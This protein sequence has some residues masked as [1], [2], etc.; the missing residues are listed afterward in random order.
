MRNLTMV[1][2]PQ[3][4]RKMRNAKKNK[5]CSRFVKLLVKLLL[6]YGRGKSRFL[7]WMIE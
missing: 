1:L 6:N 3:V 4:N 5:K 2:M 7:T